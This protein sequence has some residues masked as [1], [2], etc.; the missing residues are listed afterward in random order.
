[1]TLLLVVDNSGYVYNSTDAAVIET[2][3][4]VDVCRLVLYC[5]CTISYQLILLPFCAGLSLCRRKLLDKVDLTQ[6]M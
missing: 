1:L 4:S 6:S 3:Y 5:S 2:L